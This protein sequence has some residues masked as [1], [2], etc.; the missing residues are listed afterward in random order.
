MNVYDFDKTIFYPDS[1]TQFTL[2]CIM[3][4]PRLLVSYCPKTLL[5]A[6]LFLFKKITV[7]QAVEQ[8]SS[9]VREIPD[10]DKEIELFWN[11]NEHKIARWYLDQ[12]KE[13][14]LII[15]AAPEFLLKPL[16]DRLGIKLIGSQIDKHT[17]KVSGRC[18]YGKEKVKYLVISDYFPE[19]KIEEFYS[20]SLTDAPLASYAE[21]A[22]LVTK[23]GKKIQ[24]W[25][26]SQKSR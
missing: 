19:Q 24:P 4:Y 15:S 23:K 5:T 17:G 13:T 11:K 21:K 12:K 26:P 25:N 7:T 10:I 3:K 9:F 8:L 14:D 6:I 2:Y 1:L 18:C 16:T 20:D 22:F